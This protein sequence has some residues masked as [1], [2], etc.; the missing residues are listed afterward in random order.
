MNINAVYDPDS[1]I[2]GAQEDEGMNYINSQVI[3]GTR[4]F[5]VGESPAEYI[6]YLESLVD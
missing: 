6:D 4:V 5:K 2:T 3:E 1:L